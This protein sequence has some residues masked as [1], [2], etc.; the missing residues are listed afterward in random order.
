MIATQ[1]IFNVNESKCDSYWVSKWTFIHNNQ[2][3]HSLFDELCINNDDKMKMTVWTMIC[4]CY[5][6]S[7]QI[8]HACSVMKWRIH[9]SHSSLVFW[10][11]FSTWL[12]SKSYSETVTYRW[13]RFAMISA[14]CSNIITLSSPSGGRKS[15]AV[16]IYRYPNITLGAIYLS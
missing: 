2:N 4:V 11:N 7:H 5:I 10:I 1:L 15:F 8:S 16:W 3:W 14:R 12:R 13:C 6:A 9:L